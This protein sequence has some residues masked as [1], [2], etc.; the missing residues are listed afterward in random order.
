[1]TNTKTAAKQKTYAEGYQAAL[2]DI[3]ATIESS[4]DDSAYE[5]AA[6]ALAAVE[7]WIENNSTTLSGPYRGYWIEHTK[8][9][10]TG[11]VFDC[12]DIYESK[13]DVGKVNH[14]E[15]VT[16]MGYAKTIIDGWKRSQ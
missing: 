5:G 14:I 6:I 4:F 9:T 13:E 3:T 12:F 7:K 11:P 10:G 16:N 1:M 15:C 8:G 2:A